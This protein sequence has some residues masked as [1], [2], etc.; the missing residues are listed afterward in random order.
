MRIFFYLIWFYTCTLQAE[1]F[2]YDQ[3]VN[4]IQTQHIQSLEQ[5]L[6]QLPVAMRSNYTLV[7]QSRS[8]Q[9]ASYEN[10]RVILF[11]QNGQLTCAFNG[12]PEQTGFYSLECF[13]F[14]PH[15]RKFDFHEIRF[16]SAQSS[17]KDVL[18]SVANKNVNGQPTCLGC[19]GA[20]PRPHWNGYSTWPGAYGS[21]DDTLGI[22]LSQ[23][24]NFVARRPTHP[25]YKWLIQ[26]NS[27]T[28]P[29]MGASYDIL[30][31]PNLR[32]SDLVG[33][34]N[35]LRTTR[36][37]QQSV[38]EWQSLAFAVKALKCTLNPTQLELV[39]KSGL[40][41]EED[42]DM[43]LIFKKV[44]ML[45]HFW[46]TQFFKDPK[47]SLAQQDYEHQSGYGFLTIG[48][49]MSIAQEHALSGNIN[50]QKAFIQIDDY[51]TKNFDDIELP[52]FQTLNQILPDPH[53]FGN[54]FQT[55][56]DYICPELTK[57]FLWK[58][59]KLS[60]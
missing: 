49:G 40:N 31:R 13:Q 47:S 5:L 6:P 60:P 11:G 10:P 21:D 46:T 53:F 36:I 58:Y 18:F 3:L 14:V 7:H 45:P 34:M 38:P 56:V 28:D 2:T 32:F 1:V 59:L 52:F 29:Y 12:A 33:R 25:R 37:L 55:N 42:S 4:L 8:T 44:G 41:Y 19:H 51:F 35:A 54:Q 48:I 57:I 43:L 15:L 24:T 30:H 9:H 22:D 23:Y 17:E 39:M 26:G 50:L 27:P 20:D 16:P